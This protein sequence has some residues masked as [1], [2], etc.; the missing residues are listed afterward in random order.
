M[1]NVVSY[2]LLVSSTNT[3]C[4]MAVAGDTVEFS[5]YHVT[6]ISIIDQGTNRL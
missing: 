3:Y 5:H 4:F 1:S 6:F 2:A